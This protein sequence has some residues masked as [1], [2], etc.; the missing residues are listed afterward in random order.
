MAGNGY[1]AN[2]AE[3]QVGEPIDHAV[4]EA[5]PGI[6]GGWWLEPVGEVLKRVREGKINPAGPEDQGEGKAPESD[7]A[8][9]VPDGALPS[10]AA[11]QDEAATPRL[12]AGPPDHQA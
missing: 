12:S 8:V 4:N 5:E 2:A 10:D 6:G 3:V 7:H 9:Q 11:R 1:P